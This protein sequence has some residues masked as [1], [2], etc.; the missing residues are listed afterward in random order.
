ME[1]II[2]FTRQSKLKDI[3]LDSELELKYSI[4]QF[5]SS[6]VNSS[7]TITIVDETKD[8]DTTVLLGD[9]TNYL[10]YHSL[11]SEN[12]KCLQILESV[13]YKLKDQHTL[14]HTKIY[15]EIRNI[16]NGFDDLKF[17]EL[18]MKIVNV[19][20]ESALEFLHKCLNGKPVEGLPNDLSNPKTIPLFKDLPQKLSD[21]K[22]IPA[23]AILRDAIFEEVGI[24]S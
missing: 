7:N 3:E 2:F 16:V 11:T 4:M 1:Q 10:V 14:N 18:K 12:E 17:E 6:S 20:L 23:L 21:P 13:K 19:K 22:Y 9:N 5:K 24:Q 8:I 15:E